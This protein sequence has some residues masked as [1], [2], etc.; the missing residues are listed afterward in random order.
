MLIL[1]PKIKKKIRKEIFLKNIN[2]SVTTSNSIFFFNIFFSVDFYYHY[3]INNDNANQKRVRCNI[4]Y[5]M[6]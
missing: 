2:E 3:Y 5:F 1:V 4:V 6:I